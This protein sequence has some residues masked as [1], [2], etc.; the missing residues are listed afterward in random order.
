VQ[1]AEEIGHPQ[2]EEWREELE[3]LRATLRDK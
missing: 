1:L 3:A 2:L